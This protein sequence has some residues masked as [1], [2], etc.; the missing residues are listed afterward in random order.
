V[1]L[2]PITEAVTQFQEEFREFRDSPIARVLRIIVEPKNVGTLVKTL[3][4]E[5]WQPENKSPFL[6][7]D[8]AYGHEPDTFDSMTRI[9]CEHYALLQESFAEDGTELADLTVELSG[10]E[11][12]LLLFALHLGRFGECIGEVLD[13]PIVCWL[14]T[15]VD[16]Y[17]KWTAVVVKLLRFGLE[18][19]CRLVIADKEGDHLADPLKAMKDAAMTVRFD[20]DE[21]GL[22]DY[23]KN[24]MAA[25]SAGRAPGTLP[26]AAAPD[27]EPPPRPGPATPTD[28]Q[29]K[30]AAAAQ[31]LPPMLTEQQG[32]E[33]R[34]LVFGAAMGAKENNAEVAITNQ[35]KACELCAKAG[36]KLEQAVMTMAQAGYLLQFGS[37]DLAEKHYRQSAELATEAEAPAQ[38]AQAKM[39]LGYLMVKNGRLD[40]AAQTYEEA[41]VSADEAD[42]SMLVFET[43]RM[44]GT[45]HL[46]RGRQQDTVRCWQAAVERGKD[47][48]GDEIRQSSFLDVAGELIE[49]LR[50]NGLVQQAQSVETIVAEVG[51][52]TNA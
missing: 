36:V 46:Q 10:K 35:R 33:L 7:F 38:V 19:E 9:V 27:V 37:E 23:F 50:K 42:S 40:E 4:A 21:G 29:V 39:A 2:D 41:A 5:E 43:Q 1:V 51:E 18:R 14:P 30:A 52:K 11:E 26:G 47:A 12:P 13:P 16:N 22:G 3:R 8:T 20:I 17:K 15:N 31:N 32:E 24:M 25:P 44:A 6:I 34:R 49:L 28:E 45:C 48:S